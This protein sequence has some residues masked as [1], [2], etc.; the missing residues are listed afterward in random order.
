MAVFDIS[1]PQNEHSPDRVKFYQVDVSSTDTIQQ[2]I[3]DAVKWTE[4]TK[5]PLG[6]VVCCAGVLAAGKVR[7]PTLLL[8]YHDNY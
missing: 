7:E 2:A 5:A 8:T 4:I 3:V 6:G 1:Q